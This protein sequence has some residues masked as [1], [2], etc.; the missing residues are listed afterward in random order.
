M[1]NSVSESK[2]NEPALYQMGVTD[3]ELMTVPGER[4]RR[5]D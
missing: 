5:E 4:A 3:S 2:P 1:E